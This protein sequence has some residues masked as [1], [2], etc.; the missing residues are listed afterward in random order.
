M[1]LSSAS[2][3]QIRL[4]EAGYDSKK[5]HD[6]AASPAGEL[7]TITLPVCVRTLMRAKCRKPHDV[8]L[9]TM[10]L[11]IRRRTEAARHTTV[12]SSVDKI[13]IDTRLSSEFNFL[14]HWDRGPH[15]ARHR[16]NAA[17]PDS[18]AQLIKA[19]PVMGR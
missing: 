5:R 10:S 2:F 14:R 4:I 11:N 12:D 19:Q 17:F 1:T 6:R 16:S 18:E 8:I 7:L 9:L 15:L 3:L 13:Y